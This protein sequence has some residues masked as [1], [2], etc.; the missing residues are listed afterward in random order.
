MLLEVVDFFCRCWRWC[1]PALR[2]PRG[3]T[4]QGLEHARFAA[5]S[6]LVQEGFD[7]CLG[8]SLIFRIQGVGQSPQCWL[9]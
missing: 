8:S 2:A 6:Q 4:L 5:V 7:P 9:A 3:Y 1:L